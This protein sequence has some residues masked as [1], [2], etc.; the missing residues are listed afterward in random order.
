MY[1]VCRA[2]SSSSSLLLLFK[3]VY[4]FR[5]PFSSH[6]RKNWRNTYAGLEHELQKTPDW[7]PLSN[8]RFIS[9]SSSS[10]SSPFSYTS[11]DHHQQQ[12]HVSPTVRGGPSATVQQPNGIVAVQ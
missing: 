8:D 5:L 10:A 4:S 11:P 7:P 12:H 3:P 6:K 1:Q 9:S 2:R